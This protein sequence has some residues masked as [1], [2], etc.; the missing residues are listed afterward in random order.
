M[1]SIPLGF[2]LGGAVGFGA[3]LLLV[4][5]LG[6]LDAIDDPHALVPLLL[7]YLMLGGALVGG[8][9]GPFAVGAYLER[10]RRRLWP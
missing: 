1:L 3:A 7:L 6:A 2:V 10:R 9:G 8:V 5:V 4:E